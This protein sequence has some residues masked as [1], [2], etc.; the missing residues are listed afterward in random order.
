ML[1]FLGYSMSNF[2]VYLYEIIRL[3][4]IEAAGLF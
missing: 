4:K 1:P 2:L 3:Y